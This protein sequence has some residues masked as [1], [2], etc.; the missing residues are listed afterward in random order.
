MKTTCTLENTLRY[1]RKKKGY[2]Q[3]RLATAAGVSR[4]TIILIESNRLNPSI[5]L[6]LILAEKLNVPITTLFL[7]AEK[8]AAE[9]LSPAAPMPTDTLGNNSAF[10][11]AA[12][13]LPSDEHND[14]SGQSIWDFNN[15][16]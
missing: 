9:D 1:W 11:Y 4:Q 15:Q 5:L 6:T 14:Y 8:S 3:A 10:V 2:T 13:P 16:A 7:L 12:N